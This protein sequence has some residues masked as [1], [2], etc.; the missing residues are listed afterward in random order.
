MMEFSIE[1]ETLETLVNSDIMLKNASTKRQLEIKCMI[2][3]LKKTIHSYEKALDQEE[4]EDEYPS[5]IMI[6]D[7]QKLFALKDMLKNQQLSNSSYFEEIITN[8]QST[9]I[10]INKVQS[11]GQRLNQEMSNAAE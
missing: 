5:K 8:W 2:Q 3:Q 7:V 4:F 6:R 9:K 10:W 1:T 11:G